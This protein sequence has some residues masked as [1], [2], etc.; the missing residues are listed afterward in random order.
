[1]KNLF[2]KLPKIDFGKKFNNDQL[3]HIASLLRVLSLSAGG[4]WLAPSLLNGDGFTVDILF[5]I[6][7]I[8]PIELLALL[9]LNGIK[10]DKK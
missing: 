8:V 7:G 1:M 5:T 2:N 4:L 9:V 6:I 3:K 10:S